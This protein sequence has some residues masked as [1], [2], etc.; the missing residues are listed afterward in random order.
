MILLQVN[1]VSVTVGKLECDTP[2]AVHMD[3]VAGRLKAPQRMELRSGV[4]HVRSIPGLIESVQQTQDS[5]FQAP[6]NS[7]RSTFAPKLGQGFMLEGSDHAGDVVNTR[8]NVNKSKTRE[9]GRDS[10]APDDTPF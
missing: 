8:T 2:R 10:P 1:F 3:R 5:A 9:S 7:T 6:I 4:I